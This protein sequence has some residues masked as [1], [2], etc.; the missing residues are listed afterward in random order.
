[1]EQERIT[2]ASATGVDVTLAIAGPGARSYAFIVDLHIRVV[3]ALAWLFIGGLV[4]TGHWVP[5]A[6]DQGDPQHWALVVLLPSLALYFLYHPVVEVMMRGRTP[7]KRV[8]GVRI[9]DERGGVP[10]VGALLIRN[11]FRIVDALPGFYLLGLLM[12]V[13]TARHVRI[14]DLAAGTLL[15]IDQGDTVGRLEV[16]GSV[17]AGSTHDPA[18]VDLALDLLGRWEE[19]SEERR[20]IVALSVLRRLEPATP[21]GEL[22]VLRQRELR[23]RILDGL[24][25]EKAP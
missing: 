1:M 11:V 7:G 8:A 18:V 17:A 2:I 13:F 23:Q 24:G 3:L 14:G 9:V 15:V 19:I 16:L 25:L 12:T 20:S 6:Q 4:A 10:S 5:S 22:V 21:P